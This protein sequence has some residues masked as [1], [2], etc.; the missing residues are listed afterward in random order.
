MFFFVIRS[1][2]SLSIILSNTIYPLKHNNEFDHL[3]T[4]LLILAMSISS[5]SQY[6]F[7]IVDRLLLNK[8]VFRVKVKDL[9]IWSLT[10]GEII[11]P[12]DPFFDVGYICPVCHAVFSLTNWLNLCQKSERVYA[13]SEA[14]ADDLRK[15]HHPGQWSAGCQCQHSLA[16]TD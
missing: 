3:Y 5:F 2:F 6:Y 11:K 16:S 7:G 10:L 4:A 12:I 13:L 15:G 14:T 1:T 8:L 9:Y